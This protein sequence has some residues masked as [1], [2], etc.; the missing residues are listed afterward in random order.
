[1]TKTSLVLK[2]IFVLILASGCGSKNT[3]R[4]SGPG[5]AS[6]GGGDCGNNSCNGGPPVGSFDCG[7]MNPMACET[8]KI[9]NDQRLQ[10]GL[11]ALKV[12]AKCV[13]AAQDQSQ[14]MVDRH[15]FSHDR[16]AFPDRPA[17][18]FAARMSRM[19]IGWGGENIAQ[20]YGTADAV[21][22]GWM[23]STGHRSNILNKDYT[24]AGMGY[25]SN[26]WTQCFSFGDP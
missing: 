1:M 8:F 12:N 16:P 17:E 7:A 24:T 5:T 6:S 3:P 21:V 19:G 23:N 2:I 14:D 22:N 13:F 18:T 10:N 25:V 26:T 9:V 20:G 11:A 4:Q 15:Y